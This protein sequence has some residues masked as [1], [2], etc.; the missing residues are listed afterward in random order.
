MS[1]IDSCDVS[2]MCWN[3]DPATNQGTCVAFCSG[4]EANPSCPADPSTQCMTAFDGVLNLCLPACHPL[5][6]DCSEWATCVP[7]DGDAFFCL[8]DTSGDEG[9]YGDGCTYIDACD[10]GLFCANPAAFPACDDVACCAE[11]C[12]LALPDPSSQCTNADQGVECVS[13]WDENEDP[14][15]DESLGACIVPP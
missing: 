1:G 15:G 5:L 4:S 8:P 6:Q 10:P 2:A 11:F 7:V 9:Q 3:V 13:W 14:P 12:D